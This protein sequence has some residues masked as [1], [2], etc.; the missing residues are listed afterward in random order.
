MVQK[1]NQSSGNKESLLKMEIESR[2]SPGNC[3][4][5]R[6]LGNK[7]SLLKMEIESGSTLF[8]RL[9]SSVGCET[10]KVS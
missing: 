7:E 10:K 9:M 3:R 5:R 6:F 8:G 4:M 1:L 2:R